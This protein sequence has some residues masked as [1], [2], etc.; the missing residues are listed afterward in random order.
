MWKKKT[1]SWKKCFFHLVSQ[2]FVYFLFCFYSFAFFYFKKQVSHIK[3]ITLFHELNLFCRNYYFILESFWVFWDKNL[4]EIKKIILTKLFFLFLLD[5]NSYTQEKII[6]DQT[7][8][9]ITW[10]IKSPLPL[11]A[12]VQYNYLKLHNNGFEF[13]PA[14]YMILLFP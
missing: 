2:L 12:S 8:T 10:K 3:K 6:S 9:W 4:S 11:R 1:F 13:S 5:R 7:W 14:S